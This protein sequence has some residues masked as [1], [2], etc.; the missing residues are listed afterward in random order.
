MGAKAP[1]NWFQF[2]RDFETTSLTP[3]NAH[4]CYCVATL[5]IPRL[6]ECL[7]FFKILLQ[8]CCHRL[9][10][11]DAVGVQLRD[12]LHQKIVVVSILLL[13]RQ[14][15]RVVPSLFFCFVFFS[16]FIFFCF[17]FYFFLF[18]S[19]PLLPSFPFPSIC[20]LLHRTGNLI[21]RVENSTISFR[22]LNCAYGKT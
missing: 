14:R 6:T 7:L 8:R 1:V 2:F 16:F 4:W 5:W 13:L 21:I 18:L 20:S 15:Q 9:T 12:Y 10:L 17:F 3:I 11:T 19:F 22:E